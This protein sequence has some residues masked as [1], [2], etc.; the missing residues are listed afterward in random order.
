[1]DVRQLSGNQFSILLDELNRNIL[2]IILFE[3]SIG[4]LG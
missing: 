4:G 2:K 3:Y 1:M